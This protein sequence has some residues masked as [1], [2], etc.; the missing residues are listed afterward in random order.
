MQANVEE[1]LLRHLRGVYC[2]PARYFGS[3]FRSAAGVG[4]GL[5]LDFDVARGDC[6]V[7]FF[8]LCACGGRTLGEVDSDT[9]SPPPREDC[10]G[11]GPG[12]YAS[13]LVAPGKD[14]FELVFSTLPIDCSQLQHDCDARSDEEGLRIHVREAVIGPGV[15]DWTGEGT[16]S[17][18]Y[19]WCDF[20]GSGNSQFG[21]GGFEGRV[22]IERL[23]GIEVH[24]CVEATSEDDWWF[25]DSLDVQAFVAT[26]C[27]AY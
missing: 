14:G 26:R 9:D 20:D 10:E 17:G 4:N 3:G 1:D 24:G 22:R 12:N 11:L 27:D 2:R 18:E 8:A 21:Y 6:L 23:E 7:L 5:V 13:A 25:S 15:W 16:N 19:T